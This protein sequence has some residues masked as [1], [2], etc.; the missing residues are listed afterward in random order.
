[1][2]IILVPV[3]LALVGVLAVR[4]VDIESNACQKAP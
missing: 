3:S 2:P 1:M 4:S